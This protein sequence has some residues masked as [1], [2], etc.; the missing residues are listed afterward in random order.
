MNFVNLK[1]KQNQSKNQW[2]IITA[3]CRT[4]FM[5]I[6]CYCYLK[7]GSIYLF[8]YLFKL[9]AQIFLACSVC[10]EFQ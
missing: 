1:F 10:L 8:I 3:F 6:H 4:F 5:L 2:Y 7:K 9:L